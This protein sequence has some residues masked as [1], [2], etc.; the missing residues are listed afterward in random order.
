MASTAPYQLLEAG[1]NGPDIA[2]WEPCDLCSTSLRYPFKIQSRFRNESKTIG[3]ECFSKYFE[4]KLQQELPGEENGR[5]RA[6]LVAT[7][8]ELNKVLLNLVQKGLKLEYAVIRRG[9]I[10]ICK[11]VPA[12]IQPPELS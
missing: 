12:V 1:D 6:Q 2:D 4:E 7:R 11:E 5:Q 8:T 9:H 10:A 3:C